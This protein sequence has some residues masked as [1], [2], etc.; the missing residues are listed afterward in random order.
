MGRLVVEAVL[1]GGERE[2]PLTGGEGARE[3]V[4]AD[5]VRDCCWE[6]VGPVVLLL[7]VV[8]LEPNAPKPLKREFIKSGPERMS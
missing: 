1:T 4:L 6:S 3:V 5:G 8:R 7:L 2:V